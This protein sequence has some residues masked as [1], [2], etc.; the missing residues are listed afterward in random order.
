MSKIHLE[1][2]EREQPL[3]LTKQEQLNSSLMVVIH[4]NDTKGKF[5]HDKISRHSFY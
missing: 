1:S 3:A 5:T 4:S 2:L